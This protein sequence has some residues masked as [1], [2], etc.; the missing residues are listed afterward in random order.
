MADDRGADYLGVV[1][2]EGFP[3]TVSPI[4]AGS[5]V[6]GTRAAVVAV[7]V[8]ES[9]DIVEQRAR[10]LGASVLQLHGD[11]PPAVVA[12]L[13]ERGDWLLW[14]AV[15][16]RETED[17]EAA[18]ERYGTWVDGIL[19]E[20]W[21]AGVVGGGGVRL[22]LPPDRVRAAIPS[23]IDFILAG[24]LDPE[25]VAQAVAHFLPDV[26][27]VSSGTE[28]TTGR[29]DPERVRA[30]LDAVGA[31]SRALAAREEERRRKRFG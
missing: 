16:A 2:S 21:R 27:D 22:G 17:V 8:N 1:L 20:G 4:V 12:E 28:R 29:K 10:A 14:K 26:V 7:V 19:V 5:V 3:R 25:N 13:R 11:E 30:F 9:A 6:A 24:G 31:A 18:V 23:G 15:R